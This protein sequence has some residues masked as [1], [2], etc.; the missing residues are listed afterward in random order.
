L[1][2]GV[3]AAAT[4]PM[5]VG[6]VYFYLFAYMLASFAVFGVMTHLAG[7]NDADQELDHYAGLAKANPFLAL[8]L[9]VGL[10]SLAGIPPLVGFM[11]KL[12]IFIAAFKA[13]LYG[14]LAVAV[15]GVVVSIYYYFGWIKAAFFETWANSPD[16][17]A[18]PA[19]TPVD[20]VTGLALGALALS[21]VV[22]GFYQGPL[23]AWLAPR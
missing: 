7:P 16:A 5:A 22:L 12:F 17:P 8:V 2:L 14:L 10:G 4:V 1:L 9:A 20:F 19:R 3:A 13:E 6:A 21:T 18:K 11:G 15:V 23:G